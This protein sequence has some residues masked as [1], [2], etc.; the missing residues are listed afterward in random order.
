MGL[1]VISQYTGDATLKEV[2][3]A[4]KAKLNLLHCYRSVNYI[5][6]HMEKEFGIPWEEYNFFGW[7][8]TV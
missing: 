1:R 7:S 6:R 4:P 8:K 2:A 5:T 3:L